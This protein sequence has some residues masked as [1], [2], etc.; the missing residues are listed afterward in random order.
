MP[1]AVHE[2]ILDH[3][4]LLVLQYY[5]SYK[6]VHFKLHR[7]TPIYNICFTL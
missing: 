2:D 3:T 1:L 5:L 6:T 7:N 4:L